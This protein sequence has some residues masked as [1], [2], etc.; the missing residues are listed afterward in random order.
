MEV[1]NPESSDD[2][3]GGGEV[4][5]EGNVV[6]VADPHQSPDVRI[7]RHRRERIDEEEHSV[8]FLAGDP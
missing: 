7:V 6:N 4:G 8:Y 3:V 5:S 2:E 1:E